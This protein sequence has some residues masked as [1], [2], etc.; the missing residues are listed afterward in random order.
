MSPRKKAAPLPKDNPAE[1]ERILLLSVAVPFFGKEEY[2]AKLEASV[3][4]EMKLQFG[5]DVLTER[6]RVVLAGA[7]LTKPLPPAKVKKKTVAKP[8][9]TKSAAENELYLSKGGAKATV[10]KKTTKK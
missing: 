3:R 10:V 8:F 6:T 4:K 7:D 2:A 9:N 5:K 1:A